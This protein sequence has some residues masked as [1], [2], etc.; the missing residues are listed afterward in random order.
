MLPL[1]LLPYNSYSEW[2]RDT[3]GYAGQLGFVR[4]L[5]AQPPARVDY[6]GVFSG[7]LLTLGLKPY[8]YQVEAFEHLERGRHVVLATSTASGKSLVFQVPV[9]KAALEG[10]TTLLLYP[11]KALAHDQLSRLRQMARAFGVEERIYTYDGDTSGA[12]R[13]KAREKG[14]ALLT[15]P[16]MLHFGLLPHHS[17]WAGFLSRLHY[18]VVDE[19]HAYRG[20]FGTHV[21][22]ILQRL[23][24]LAWH[25]GASPQVIAA[26]ATIANPAEHAA[27][28]TG[29]NFHAVR[30]NPSRA[31]REFGVWTPK[32][33]DKEGKLRRSPNL[34]AA[35]LARHL[36]EQGLRTLIFTNARRTAELVA[37]YAA[38]EQVR[39]YR[40]GYTA[41]ERRRLEQALQEGTVRVL[42][43]TSALELGVDIGG[44]DAVILLGYPGSVSSFWQR[45]GRAGRSNRR[46]L[47]LWIPRE[48][49]LDAYFE[50]HPE[51]LLAGPP[52]SAMADPDNP[53]LYPAHAHCAAREL[54][55][56]LPAAEGPAKP[57]LDPLYK[58]WLNIKPPLVERY[59]RLYSPKRSPHRDVVLRGLGQGFSL[60]DNTGQLLGTLDE[61]QAYW[62][63]HPGA[64][65][66]HQGE[67]YLVRNLDPEKREIVL[68]PGLEDY[69]TQPRAETEIEVL[70]GEEI[71]SGIWVGP[72]LLR[73]RVTGYVK[74]RFVSETVLE[75]V[76]LLMP[77]LTFQTE[78]IW[79]HP[80]EGL[81]VLPTLETGNPIEASSPDPSLLAEAQV[82]SAIH[83][84]EHTLIGLLPLL[85]LAERQDIG[86]VSY[87]FY[88]RPLPSGS[89]PTIFIYDGYPGGVGYARAAARQ[90]PRWVAAARDL[91]QSC[92]CET[93]CPRCILSPKC[94]NGNQF[95]DKPTARMLAE[96]LSNRYK[97]GKPN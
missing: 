42:V 2:L 25:Y 23:L 33:L 89:G 40:A 58:P 50:Q 39:P 55:I 94:G 64:V 11:T 10:Q 80:C 35:L 68:L 17:D 31:E 69:Y 85:V 3:E 46:A 14:R 34:E 43:S 49:P 90:F 65:Y 32:A 41:A 60:R 72:V 76:A 87:P 78:A 1:E 62:E 44:L 26:S 97:S 19:L 15:N 66:L 63:A 18:I 88:P 36:A 86:G 13:K 5:P 53:V 95:L 21:A 45:A 28:L 48:D 73:E 38:N 61:R 84:L 82:P 67:S 27:N 30:A 20:V 12:E 51:L 91:L 59:G 37:R 9:L 4:L 96:A 93:G 92:P 52:E 56:A 81:A 29:L 6:Q 77:E 71:L 70:Q 79:F 57:T 7:V 8:S 83:A 75:E 54:P 24:R 74:K 47:V 16:D 22:L